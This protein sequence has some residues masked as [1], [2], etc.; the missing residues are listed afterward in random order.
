MTFRCACGAKAVIGFGKDASP[1]HPAVIPF[2]QYCSACF[3]AA[4]PD[5]LDRLDAA[6][7]VARDY[8]DNLERP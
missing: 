8:L 5:R 6:V 2:R 4:H 3:A 7:Q 1:T